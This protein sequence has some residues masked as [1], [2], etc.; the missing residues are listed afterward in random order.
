MPT[1]KPV[2]QTVVSTAQPE[3]AGATVRRSI[4]THSLRNLDPFLMLDEFTVLQ[5]AG[6]P[7][8][9]HRGFETVTYMLN[10]A[11]QHED[12]AGHKGIIRP[13][14][15]QWMTAGRGIMHAEMPAS[16]EPAHGL[17]LWVN[18]P[19]KDKM[20]KPRYQ[21]LLDKNV[22]RAQ[23]PDGGVS[24]KVIAG[25]SYGVKAAV[26]TYTPIIYL[27]VKMEPGK[28]FEQSIPENW[29]AFMYTLD[30]TVVVGSSAT[31]VDPHTTVVLGEDGD[32][33]KVE[34]ADKAHFVVIAG[35]KINE[36]IAQHGPFVLNDRSEIMQAFMDYEMG[37][38]GFEGAAEW[39][40]KIGGRGGR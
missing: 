40:S 18:L 12:F 1:Y 26:L 39:A 20:V 28:I 13:G 6:F 38:N 2:K 7:D 27:D 8:H 14:D 19:K 3:G 17:Q 31:K 24:V 35:Q 9:P 23:S 25:E 34:S 37:R 16:D 21:E 10:G 15:L 4:G 32:T 30:G 22:P 29:T 11:M 33:L 5:P 36:P